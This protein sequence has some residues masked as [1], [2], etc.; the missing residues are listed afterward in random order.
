MQVGA[1]G[2]EISAMYYSPYI[3]NTNKISSASLD[4]VQP[5]DNDVSSSKY[6]FS[7]LVSAETENPLKRG[8]TSNLEDLINM[9]FSMSDNIS[10]RI[11][12]PENGTDASQ[13]ESSVNNLYKMSQA[14]D[15][16]AQSV[17]A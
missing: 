17:T 9:Q 12:K 14:V 5:I 1:I 16:Y 7:G 6:D 13:Q 8:E 4:K 3:Y 10:S 2:S 15:A 11:V